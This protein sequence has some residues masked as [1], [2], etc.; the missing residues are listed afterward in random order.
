[1]KVLT[2]PGKDRILGVTIVGQN[3]GE[4]L[5]EFTFAMKHGMGLGKI[6]G[7]IHTYPTMGEANKF[8]AGEW[9]KK[10]KPEWALNLLERYFKWAR[11]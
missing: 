8:V 2:P 5:T 6:L 10:H 7:T 9:R 1:M 3:A 11:S 4:L